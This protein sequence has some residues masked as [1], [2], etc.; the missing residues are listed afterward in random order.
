MLVALDDQN[1]KENDGWVKLRPLLRKTPKKSAQVGYR[2]H[3]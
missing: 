1:T 3:N 2:V